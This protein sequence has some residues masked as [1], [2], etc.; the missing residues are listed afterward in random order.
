[1]SHGS[2]ISG[3]LSTTRK[4]KVFLET[5]PR[6]KGR[7]RGIGSLQSQIDCSIGDSLHG[8]VSSRSE[9]SR[10]LAEMKARLASQNTM[11]A[12]YKEMFDVLVTQDDRLASIMARHLS[13]Q[14]PGSSSAQ[15]PPS[16]SDGT[17]G[18]GTGTNST[19]F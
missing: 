6:K 16:P 15:H 5:A 10:E 8:S 18:T 17:D 13:Q 12:C 1:M 3:G 4:N 7:I 9:E 2:E 11:L 19:Q 14:Q